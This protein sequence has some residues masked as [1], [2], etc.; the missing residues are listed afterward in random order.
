MA[1]HAGSGPWLTHRTPEQAGDRWA[2]REPLNLELLGPVVNTPEGA[3]S[4]D[5]LEGYRSVLV[6]FGQGQLQLE[7]VA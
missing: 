5:V 1:H 7:L 4:C 6:S 3:A 2:S